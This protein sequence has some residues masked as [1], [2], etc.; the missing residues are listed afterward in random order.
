[1]I[2]K[3]TGY[4][5]RE[6]LLKLANEKRIYLDGNLLK[7]L[8]SETNDTE[9]SDYLQ[10]CI[11]RDHAARRKRLEVTKKVQKQNKDLEEASEKN[12]QLLADLEIALAESKQAE[13]YA[14]DLQGK[15]T[16]AKQKALED[17]D[18]LQKKAQFKMM[19]LIVK[20]ALGIIIGVGVF[21][22]GLYVYV[23]AAGVDSTI[24]ESTWSNLFGILL[25]NSFSIIGTIM[26]VRYANRE[27]N[28]SDEFS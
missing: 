1:M 10:T 28:R 18:F 7:V 17:L 23:I 20:M 5:I 6:L 26:G 27:M 9:F 13:Q 2:V 4:E 24:V 8:K 3:R 22:T 15:E 25:T 19:G 11:S 21:T 16:I 12:L 14:T